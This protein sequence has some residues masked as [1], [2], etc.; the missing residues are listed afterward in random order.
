MWGSVLPVGYR[1]V[2][3]VQ[4]RVLEL[5]GAEFHAWLRHKKFEHV[6]AD[7]GMHVLA[8]GHLLTTVVLTPPNAPHAVRYRLEEEN[9]AGRWV[10]TLTAHQPSGDREPG[11]LWIAVKAPA[12]AR[13]SE[14][15]GEHR[16]RQARFTATPRLVRNI[17]GAVEAYNGP[18]RLNDRPRLVLDE[19][20]VDELIDAFCDP[21]RTVPLQVAGP[22]PGADQIRWVDQVALWTK[23][24]VGMAAT[25]VLTE[26]ASEALEQ[27]VGRS[28]AVP[29]GSIRSYLPEVDPASGVDARRHRLLSART[30]AETPDGRTRALLASATRRHSLALPLPTRLTRLDRLLT[31]SESEL[32]FEWAARAAR[33]SVPR[34]GDRSTDVPRDQARGTEG[35]SVEKTLAGM[36]EATGAAE[37]ARIRDLGLP[38][39]EPVDTGW[40]LPQLVGLVDEFSEQPDGKVRLQDPTTL[41][42]TLRTVL[43]AGR[44]AQLSQRVLRGRLERLEAESA[45]VT[46]ETALLRQN[47]DEAQFEVADALDSIRRL[48]AERD[49]L[50]VELAKVDMGE[51]AWAQEATPDEAPGAFSEMLEWLDEGRLPGIAF[52]GDRGVALDLEPHDPWGT[53]ASRAWD[54]LRALS[55]YASARTS[56]DHTGNFHSYCQ[57]TPPGYPGWSANNHAAGESATVEANPKMRKQRELPVPSCVEPSETIFMGAHLKVASAKSI[58]PRMYYHDDVASS[59]MVYVGYIGRHLTNTMS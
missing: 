54:G 10:T 58:S 47:L 19:D 20:E 32:V 50:R 40:V 22:V 12:A 59:G 27:K 29:A 1:S 55:G 37:Q 26:R 5:A 31:K 13:R 43:L 46:E 28:H 56:G 4:E 42:E 3:N 39:V 35:E 17:L 25:Y 34:S 18:A 38:K 8:D 45:D 2:L 21:E 51:V 49:R 30:L 52:T 24:T 41:V 57:T 16:S 33:T 9:S 15:E 48:E 53:W 36:V 6:P 14:S 7:P 23:E 11:W 44:S